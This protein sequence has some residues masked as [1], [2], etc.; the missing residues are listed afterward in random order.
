M[1]MGNKT[2]IR[3]AVVKDKSQAGHLIAPQD[4]IVNEVEVAGESATALPTWATAV[5]RN[6]RHPRAGVSPG[7]YV[8]PGMN[9][10]LKATH[11]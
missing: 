9:T 4:S 3:V 11:S 7:P 1:T 5:C 10:C 8:L 6:L 2:M